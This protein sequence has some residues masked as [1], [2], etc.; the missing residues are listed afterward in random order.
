MILIEELAKSTVFS[1]PER[2]RSTLRIGSE[3]D[4]PVAESKENI[5]L[6]L[7]NLRII[8]TGDLARLQ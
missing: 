5:A 7:D 6:Q 8:G 1:R 4:H 2:V 3:K